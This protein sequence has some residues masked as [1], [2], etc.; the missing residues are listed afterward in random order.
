M[1]NKLSTRELVVL[2][3]MGAILYLSQILLAP[4]PNIE[5][6]SF[7]IIAYTVKWKWKVFYPI[8]LFVFLQGITYNFGTWWW[9]YLYVWSL[10][11]LVVILLG[12]RMTPFRC[13]VLGGFFGLLFGAMCAIPYLLIGG[14][15]MAAAWWISGIPFDLIHCVS[16][17]VVGLVLW[18]PV[19][20]IFKTHN[21][22]TP[23]R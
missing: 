15:S 13:A 21:S 18:N 17:A 10:L 23:D 22:W 1:K 8:Y 14:V 5:V 12:C 3:L 9:S 16:N 19:S 20:R 7:L 2:G 11:A 4:L 6:I